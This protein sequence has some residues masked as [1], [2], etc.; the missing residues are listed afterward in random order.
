MTPDEFR[1]GGHALIDWIADYLEDI[2]ERP[3]MRTIEPGDVRDA[4][5]AHP[6]T[7]VEP[8]IPVTRGVDDDSDP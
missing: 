3:V 5:P 1:A 8:E 6:P 7:D 4:L 2:E